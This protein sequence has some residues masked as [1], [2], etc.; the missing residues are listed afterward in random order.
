MNNL[1][2]KQARHQAEIDWN[3]QEVRYLIGGRLS[4]KSPS[5]DKKDIFYPKYHICRSDDDVAFVE[6]YNKTINQL[7]DENGIPDWSP[8]YRVPS[9]QLVLD[10]LNKKGQHIDTYKRSSISEK[11]SVESL[12]KKWD[13]QGKPIMWARLE[14]R[15]LLL[16]AGNINSKAGRVEIL[17]LENGKGTWMA[18]F[19]FLRKQ[20]PQ[21]PW[22]KFA[23]STDI[24]SSREDR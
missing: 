10:E 4:T 15:K 16:L 19:E 1:V 22:D 2:I 14:N 13:A 8:R 12:C 5:L 23:V 3:N 9:R 17:D 20:C 18:S 11:R 7:V 21:M 6:A 24:K